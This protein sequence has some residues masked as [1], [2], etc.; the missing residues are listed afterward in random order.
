MN[1]VM[2]VTDCFCRLF[3]VDVMYCPL[4]LLNYIQLKED[5]RDKCIVFSFYK[6]F[7]HTIN[8]GHWALAFGLFR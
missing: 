8:F 7:V 4:H 6:A 2:C 5:N 1:T 3:T